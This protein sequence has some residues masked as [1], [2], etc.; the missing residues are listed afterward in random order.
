MVVTYAIPSNLPTPRPVVIEEVQY[1]NF[2]ASLNEVQEEL[3]Q[4][5]RHF[6]NVKVFMLK[7]IMQLARP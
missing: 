7:F 3:P 5:R 2:S 6:Q 1:D 4:Q